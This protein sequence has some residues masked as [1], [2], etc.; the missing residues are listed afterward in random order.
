MSDKEWIE[1]LT[2]EVAKKYKVILAQDD[3][4]LITAILN[5]SIL[6]K[7]FH[8]YQSLFVKNSKLLQ[9]QFKAQAL[10]NEKI[11][12]HVTDRLIKGPYITDK[13]INYISSSSNKLSS[14]V[15][16][17]LF[18]VV[19]LIGLVSGLALVTYF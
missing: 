15:L 9:Q 19:F 4:V 17:G 2:S 3:P 7:A 11:L 14:I 10:S 1:E 6:D 13:P 16:F 12:N 8:E 18:L 5:K